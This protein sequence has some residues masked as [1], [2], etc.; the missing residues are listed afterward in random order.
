MGQTPL[1]FWLY[2]PLAALA[3]LGIALILFAFFRDRGKPRRRCPKCWYDMAGAA[4][5]PPVRC[6]ECGHVSHSEREL[7]RRR[8]RWW[9]AFVGYILIVPLLAFFVIRDGSRVYY[10][11][12]P[13]WKLAEE[14]R[15]NGT[16][17]S[18][19]V[20]RDPDDRGGRFVLSS[21]GTKLLNVEDFDIEFGE[22]PY[23]PMPS[24]GTPPCRVGA[25]E[26]LNRGGKR[27]L[28]VF[29]FSGG[30]HCCYTVYVIDLADPPR[31]IATI[32]A[33]NGMGLTRAPAGD[34]HFPELE[35]NIADQSFDYW[36]ASHADSPA[37]SVW[38]RIENGAL[39]IALDKMIESSETVLTRHPSVRSIQPY[40]E[41]VYD[42][43]LRIV[44]PP[45]KRP[46]L[47]ACMLNLLYSGNEAACWQ[48]FDRWWPDRF[49]GPPSKDAFKQEFLNTLSKSAQWHDFQAARGAVAEGKPIPP[50]S[51]GNYK[52]QS[53]GEPSPAA[54]TP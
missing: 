31:I 5:T 15:V 25:G 43:K 48:L 2:L 52:P 17:A 7:A 18:R 21:N 32:D 36:H 49:V 1:A 4:A 6:P 28:V 44:M 26:D 10:A 46:E 11:V 45:W 40:P 3:V 47:W 23:D 51:V 20:I 22:T 29:S 24:A 19:Y 8:R 34:P 41:L 50:A 37:P 42:G 16:R 33:R 54:P 38:Y 30:A 53:L 9:L 13:K 35:F 39:R 14:I 12:M 27:Y